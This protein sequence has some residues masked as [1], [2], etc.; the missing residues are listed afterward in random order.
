MVESCHIDMTEGDALE[1][2]GRIRGG[3]VSAVKPFRS[4]KRQKPTDRTEWTRWN[5]DQEQIIGRGEDTS[6]EEWR[7]KFQW[8]GCD[9]VVAGP[10]CLDR[11]R[12][13]FQEDS[14]KKR[15]RTLPK[16][17]RTLGDA[18]TAKSSATENPQN[19]AG[20]DPRAPAGEGQ[21]KN[22]RSLGGKAFGAEGK[23]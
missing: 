4:Y 22:G 17:I 19:G 15:L 16:R 7:F 8:R 12:K 11:R 10:S 13:K 6:P 20:N 21:V 14:E 18:A 23:V 9:F 1:Q 3:T 2:G 5:N